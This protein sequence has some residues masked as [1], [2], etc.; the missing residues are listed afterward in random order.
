MKS[1]VSQAKSMI[2]IKLVTDTQGEEHLILMS[3]LITPVD[4]T[5]YTLRV[6][7]IYISTIFVV[8]A[9]AIALVISNI[10]SKPIRKI[11]E[12]AKNLAGGNFDTRF[13][14]RGYREVEELSHTLNYAAGELGKSER[15]RETFWPMFHTICGLRSL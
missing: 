3:M 1:Y 4:A 9:V 14:G 8:T 12:S 15:F 6:Q 13:D 5:V 10:T 11:N 2:Y 7:F